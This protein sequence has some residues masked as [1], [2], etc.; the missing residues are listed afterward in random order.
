MDGLQI[1]LAI[2]IP[3]IVSVLAWTL[4]Y[5][6]PYTSP[7]WL[8]NRVLTFTKHQPTDPIEIGIIINQFSKYDD[9]KRLTANKKM[10]RMFIRKIREI[11]KNNKLKWSEAKKTVLN[12]P[13]SDLLDK[14]N[15]LLIVLTDEEYE[16]KHNI[17]F[18]SKEVKEYFTEKLNELKENKESYSQILE[19]HPKTLIWGRW[20]SGEDFIEI[21]NKEKYSL[22]SEELELIS[23]LK[24][25]IVDKD[26]SM[27]IERFLERNGHKYPKKM[28][29]KEIITEFNEL[30]LYIDYPHTQSKKD[31]LIYRLAL[32]LSNHEKSSE[33]LNELINE[34]KGQIFS[35]DYNEWKTKFSL[36]N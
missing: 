7:N 29:N 23:D 2:F 5:I 22:T 35:K 26:R 11:E 32:G 15:E 3:L 6:I 31:E 24:Y 17:K 1:F 27:T 33:T 10:K 20:Y 18:T 25:N 16:A 36:D 9:W 4:T 34:V 12:I 8:S 30:M 19:K 13:L 28:D 21:Y 14:L